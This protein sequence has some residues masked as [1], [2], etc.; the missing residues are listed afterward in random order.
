MCK[1]NL[2]HFFKFQGGQVEVFFSTSIFV[3]AFVLCYSD[4]MY[5]RATS[6]YHSNP[7]QKVVFALGNAVK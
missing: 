5:E 4:V 6:F 2:S 7:L 3:P 1:E